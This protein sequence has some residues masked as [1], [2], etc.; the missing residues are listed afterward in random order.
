MLAGATDAARAAADIVLTDPGLSVVIHAIIIARQ[1]FQRVKNFIN[2]ES[3][4]STFTCTQDCGGRKHASKGARLPHSGSYG[5]A[6]PSDCRR[7]L[8]RPSLALPA[9]PAD[10]IAATLQLLTFFFIAVFAFEPR[11]FC[12]TGF[13]RF[14][15]YSAT[16][17]NPAD[18]TLGYSPCKI[19]GAL[20]VG[21]WG[22]QGAL[23]RAAAHF[24]TAGR[25]LDSLSP[26]VGKRL[27]P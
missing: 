20:A 6:V 8:T 4:L 19:E 27:A 1:I 22:W 18:V 10:R 5:A 11:N 2:C 26:P 3:R 7:A 13:E 9:T 16:G 25:P 24:V 15:G 23:P 17:F 14:T 12:I 21:R